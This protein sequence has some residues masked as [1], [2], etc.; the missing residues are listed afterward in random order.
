[1]FKINTLESTVRI[2]FDCTTNK[3][4]VCIDFFLHLK[5]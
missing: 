5:D 3:D 1:M 4:G 2:D